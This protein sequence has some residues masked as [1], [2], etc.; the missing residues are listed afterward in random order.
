M[1]TIWRHSEITTF[2][3]NVQNQATCDYMQFVLFSMFHQIPIQMWWRLL[4]GIILDY[5]HD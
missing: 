4:C 5:I 1:V 3:H 2:S